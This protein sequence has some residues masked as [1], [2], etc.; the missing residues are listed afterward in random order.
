MKCVIITLSFPRIRWN[1]KSIPHKAVYF[2]R[3]HFKV[4][5]S[6]DC[7]Q[8][9]TRANESWK[10]N[11]TTRKYRVF[12]ILRPD[13][14]ELWPLSRIS[15]FFTL[16]QSSYLFEQ[17]QKKTN[18]VYLFRCTTVRST[19]GVMSNTDYLHPATKSL[20][21]VCC[22]KAKTTNNSSSSSNRCVLTERHKQ[23]IMH[24]WTVTRNST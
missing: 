16:F 7:G 21:N 8:R 11:K 19:H 15:M 12:V 22:F 24:Q 9:H 2:H 18:I 5:R 23:K 20:I 10:T 4:D 1:W 3:R 13:R 14:N 6:E 17:R